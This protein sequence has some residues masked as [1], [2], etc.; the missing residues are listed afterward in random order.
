M[1]LESYRKET[2][3][4]ELKQLVGDPSASG[5]SVRAPGCK[6]EGFL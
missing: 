2:R 3:F 4:K 6:P 1:V 5:R